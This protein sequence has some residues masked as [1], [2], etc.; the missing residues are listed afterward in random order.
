MFL[1]SLEQETEFKL[2]V[3]KVRQTVATANVF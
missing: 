2:I 3:Q 1:I